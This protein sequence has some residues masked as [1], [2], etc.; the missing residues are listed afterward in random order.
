MSKISVTYFKPRGLFKKCVGKKRCP[1]GKVRPAIFWLGS[2]RRAAEDAAERI[3]DDVLSQPWSLGGDGIWTERGL[4][5]AD[6]VIRLAKTCHAEIAGLAAKIYRTTSLKVEATTTTAV[7][8]SLAAVPAKE[9]K[10]TLYK[11]IE[12]Y[13]ERMKG[14]RISDQHRARA[15]QVVETNLKG[16]RKDCSISDIDYTW[17]ESLCDHYK[18]RPASLKDGTPLKPA[19]VKNVLTY[20]RLFFQWMDDATWGSWRTARK[21]MKPFRVC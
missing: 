1:D 9:P 16:A 13:V 21:L 10:T 8:A 4:E 19:G 18:N 7:A 14:K 2:D 3:V 20:L 15:I 5:A 6:S 11:A 12:A 17:I